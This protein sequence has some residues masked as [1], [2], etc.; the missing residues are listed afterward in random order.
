MSVKNIHSI[1]SH[2]EGE[3]QSLNQKGRKEEDQKQG[4]KKTHLFRISLPMHTHYWLLIIT[5]IVSQHSSISGQFD[6]TK[7]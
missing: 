5:P 1:G 7:S 2:L 6:L 4:K 3:Y